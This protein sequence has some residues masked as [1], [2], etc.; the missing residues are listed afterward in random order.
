MQIHFSGFF[1]MALF[2]ILK[3]QYLLILLVGGNILSRSIRFNKSNGCFHT[4]SDS[5]LVP[6]RP[7]ISA[8][9]DTGCLPFSAQLRVDFGAYR[10]PLTNTL[11]DWNLADA[12]NYPNTLPI[13]SNNQ[14][15]PYTY[16]SIGYL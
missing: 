9:K 12:F 6:C 1:M 2:L 4:K 3:I 14:V 11:M 13:N 16:S 7:V 15:F 8:V 5:T 10:S